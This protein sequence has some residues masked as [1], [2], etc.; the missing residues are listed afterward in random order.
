MY[1]VLLTEKASADLAWF[2]VSEQRLILD[3]IIENLTTQPTLPTRNRKLLRPNPIASWALRLGEYRVFYDVAAEDALVTVLAIGH[4]DHN[5][6][7]V[8]GERV[9]I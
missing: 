6:L 4:K 8:Q 7:Y 1:E 5:D 2:R 3:G 9:V